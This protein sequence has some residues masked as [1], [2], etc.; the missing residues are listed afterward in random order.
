MADGILW[1]AKESFREGKVNYCDLGA[2]FGVRCGEFAADKNGLADGG[3]V[4]RSHIGRFKVAGF[5][6]GEGVTFNDVAVNLLI[7][8]EFRVSRGRGRDDTGDTIERVNSTGNDLRSAVFAVAGVGWIEA[9][10]CLV[11]GVETNR[12]LAEVVECVNEQ[13]GSAQKENAECDL[14]ANRNFAETL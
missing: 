1:R 13:S 14:H 11:G 7:A 5:V 12:L 2:A 8:G 4:S 6:F 3:E 10:G 9:E